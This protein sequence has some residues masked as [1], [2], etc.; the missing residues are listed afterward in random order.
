MGNSIKYL[1]G[2]FVIQIALSVLLLANRESLTAFEPNEAMLPFQASSVSSIAITGPNGEEVSLKK[3]GGAWKVANKFNFPAAEGRISK[4]LDKLTELKKSWPVGTTERAAKQFKVAADDFERRLQL[5]TSGGNKHTIYFGNSPA[6]KKIHARVDGED[7]SYALEFGSHEANVEATHWLDRELLAL[8]AEEITSVKLPNFEI[9][10]ADGKFSIAGIKES[11]EVN[12]EKLNPLL[13]TI[14]SQS[15]SDVLGTEA[16]D[17]FK[18]DEKYLEYTVK[19]GDEA[20]TFTYTGPFEESSYVLKVSSL[21]Y[22]FKVGN[23]AITELKEA[24][25]TEMIT[26]KEAEEPKA[27][28]ANEEAAAE[29]EEGSG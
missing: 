16:K 5:E 2:L 6:F 10:Q 26:E 7:E 12:S 1:T 29:T 19:K 20:L 17:E 11:E 24:T 21:P 9:T 15:F 23:T 22:Y 13:N 4:L 25:R 18:L 14:K 8:K 3:D 28:E 27:P